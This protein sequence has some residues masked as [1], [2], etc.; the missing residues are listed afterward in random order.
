MNPTTRRCPIHSRPTPPHGLTEPY[1]VASRFQIEGSPMSLG[2]FVDTREAVDHILDQ[3][4]T[5]GGTIIRPPLERPWGIYAGYFADPDNPP[6]EA[7]Y[8]LNGQPPN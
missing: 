1:T 4:E 7:V 8:F 2:F 5:A 3:A 6:L